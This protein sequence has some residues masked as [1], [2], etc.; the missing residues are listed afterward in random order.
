VIDMNTK[1]EQLGTAEVV[2]E[3]RI[4][5]PAAKVWKALVGDATG[6]WHR[7]FMTSPR[8]VSFTIEPKLGGRVFEDYGGGDGLVWGTVIGL[9]TNQLLMTV[10]DTSPEWGGPNRS[11][12]TWR[13]SE[14]DGVT[15]VRFTQSLF[16]RVDAAVVGSLEN[17][18]RFLFEECL[19]R[20]VETGSI[21]GAGA[22][23]TE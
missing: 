23:P 19:K 21:E 17:G 1:K 22:A 12:M 4:A 10:G 5:A 20:F 16:G 15:T 8:T 6:W 13:L 11:F 7:A 14:A 9:T 2:A 3:I 18:W